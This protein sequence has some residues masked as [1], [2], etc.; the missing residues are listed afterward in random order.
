[1]LSQAVL[2]TKVTRHAI[3]TRNCSLLLHWG[4]HFFHA[5]RPGEQKNQLWQQDRIKLWN[6]TS[7][8]DTV[9]F[10]AGDLFTLLDDCP[11]TTS[12]PVNL[13]SPVAP[14]NSTYP[15]PSKAVCSN[16]FMHFHC[17]PIIQALYYCLTIQFSKAAILQGAEK[18]SSILGKEAWCLWCTLTVCIEP[19]PGICSNTCWQSYQKDHFMLGEYIYL[20]DVRKAIAKVCGISHINLSF[21]TDFKCSCLGLCEIS[22]TFCNVGLPWR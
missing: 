19:S 20:N 12:C 14:D 8:W 2:S 13:N 3:C 6:R 17:W 11:L 18:G 1:M 9:L 7:R 21:N 15:W 16:M 4:T 5:T 22:D 10:F